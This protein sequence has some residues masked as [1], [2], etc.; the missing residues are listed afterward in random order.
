RA[1]HAL[2]QREAKCDPETAWVAGMLAPLGWFGVCAIDSGAVAACRADPEFAR[3][4]LGAQKRY[5]GMQARALGRRLARWG[6]LP[7]WLAAVVGHLA[8]PTETAIR[9]GAESEL[10]QLVQRAVALVEQVISADCKLHLVDRNLGNEYSQILGPELRC[11]GEN[12]ASW[13]NPAD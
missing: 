8:L 11:V 3:H 6:P 10:F 7:D 4:P 13:Q 9:F 1:A 5:W 2:A 12:A